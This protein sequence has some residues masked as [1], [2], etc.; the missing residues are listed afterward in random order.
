MPPVPISTGVAVATGFGTVAVG[1]AIALVTGIVVG[2]SGTGTAGKTDGTLDGTVI[3]V[4]GLAIVRVDVG[5]G[6]ER[7]LHPASRPGTT[8]R[9]KAKINPTRRGVNDKPIRELAIVGRLQCG[10]DMRRNQLLP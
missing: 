5:V 7:A 3:T 10:P 4:V 6:R 9:R 8:K 1:P 2:A